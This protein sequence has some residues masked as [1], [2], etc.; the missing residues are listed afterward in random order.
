M[1]W[2]KSCA[3]ESSPFGELRVNSN[4]LPASISFQKMSGECRIESNTKLVWGGRFGICNAFSRAWDICSMLLPEQSNWG[5]FCA[6][7]VLSIEIEI[8]RIFIIL[9]GEI[10]RDKE[11][12]SLCRI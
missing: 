12:F 8:R 2:A 5:C 10:N 7:F 11:E 3:V 1:V 4:F 9:F 6:V